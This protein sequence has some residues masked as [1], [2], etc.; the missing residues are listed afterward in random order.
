MASSIWMVAAE[1]APFAQVGGL[2]DVLRGLPAALARRGL[3]VRRF[4]PAYG[5]IRR[6]GFTPEEDNLA[7]SL[8]PARTPVRFLTRRE[9]EGVLTT[10][11]ECEELYA[12]EGIYGPPGGEFPD[13]A[14]RFALL[15]RAVCERARRAV[16]PPGVLHAHDWHAAAVPLFA[17]FLPGWPA[18][19]RTVLTVHNLG[20]QGRFGA[21]D[22]DWLSLPGPARALAFRPEILEDH[23]GINLLKA[24]LA[25]ADRITTVSPRHA[26]EILTPEFGFGLEGLLRGRRGVLRGI[27]NGADYDA[28]DPA[29]DRHLPRPYGP[30]GL[31]AKGR[32]ARALRERLGLPR[33][34]RPILGALG[35]LAHQKGFDVLAAAAPALLDLG[36]DLVL[37]GSGDAALEA[38]LR[39][40]G[41]AHPGRVGVCL[42]FDPDLAHLLT[43][44]SDLLLVPSRYE[45]CGLVQMHALR[46]GTPP[47][48]HRTGGLA[49]T[50]LDEDETPGRGTGFA[51]DSLSPDALVGAV[52][53]ALAHRTGDPSSWRALQRRA[54]AADFSWERAAAEYAALYDGL[55]GAGAGSQGSAPA[56]GR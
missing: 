53:R 10:L 45:P 25:C 6:E 31:E 56:A 40:A 27:L 13:N 14:R 3:S 33:S 49:D 30:D 9:P 11:V 54:M 42:T 18:R 39:E 12:R 23:G 2:G 24:G 5:T 20:H 7:V 52:R 17:R 44:G 19:P 28:W 50:V 35:R 37:V 15:A 43:G 48:V 8:G 29:R 26:E 21:E 34:D 46:Y 1:A 16:E 4:L 36:A 55:Q 32:A 47:V 38:R 41:E 22:L 51:F